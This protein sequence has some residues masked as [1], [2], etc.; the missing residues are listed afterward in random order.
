VS[1]RLPVHGTEER[2]ERRGIIREVPV[3][4]LS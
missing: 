4:F 2:E 1:V 3:A